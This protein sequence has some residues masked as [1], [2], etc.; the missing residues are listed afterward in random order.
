MTIESF[1]AKP[2]WRWVWR[3]QGGRPANYRP[4]LPEDPD[5]PPKDM[6]VPTKRST[7]IGWRQVA[8]SDLLDYGDYGMSFGVDFRLRRF[9][10]KTVAV[11]L[12]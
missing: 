8:L 12:M 2:T 1:A 11:V 6:K 5:Q 3:G 7:R 10:D 4:K 9:R